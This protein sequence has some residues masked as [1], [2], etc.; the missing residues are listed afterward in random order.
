MCGLRATGQVVIVDLPGE[1]DITNADRVHTLLIQALAPGVAVLIADLTGTA[2]CDAGGVRAIVRARAQ[3]VAGGSDIWL[4]VRPGPVRRI[5]DLIDT[6]RQ[7]PV[8]GSSGEA[9]HARTP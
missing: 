7:L 2:F 1:I 5:L 4:A 8:Y 3:A 6:G 9:V